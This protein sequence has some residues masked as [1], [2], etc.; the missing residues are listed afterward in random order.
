MCACT[1]DIL[2]VSRGTD[3]VVVSL[4]NE[5]V[6]AHGVWPDVVDRALFVLFD[7]LRQR[8]AQTVKTMRKDGE[9]GR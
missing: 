5:G 2:G 8:T 9:E 4:S 3:V 6:E 1:R 7:L